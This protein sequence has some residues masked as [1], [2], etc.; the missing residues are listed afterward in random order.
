M[1]SSN[2]TANVL[3]DYNHCD[4]DKCGKVKCNEF[5]SYCESIFGST[6]NVVLKFVKNEDQYRKEINAREDNDLDSKYIMN[7][8]KVQH[9]TE[10]TIMTAIQ[11]SKHKYLAGTDYKYMIVMPA[12]DRCLEDIIQNEALGETKKMEILKAPTFVFFRIWGLN[13]IKHRM[14]CI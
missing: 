2:Y 7:H 1:I 13:F 3:F 9:L 11:N 10:D 12:A 5:S 14:L 6:R 8:I 4:L